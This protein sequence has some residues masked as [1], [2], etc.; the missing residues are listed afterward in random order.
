[1]SQAIP[2]PQAFLETYKV[3]LN[4]EIEIG[5]TQNGRQIYLSIGP[6]LRMYLRSTAYNLIWQFFIAIG[7]FRK[8]P[9]WYV[10]NLTNMV[11][12]R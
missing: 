10:T 4:V 9:N 12:A 6:K 7:Q 3:V 5:L 8:E 11:S 2:K 1:M